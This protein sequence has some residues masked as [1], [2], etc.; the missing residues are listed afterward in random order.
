MIYVGIDIAKKK[1]FA[2]VMN[3][4]GEILVEAFS[5]NNDQDGFSSLL[6]KISSF[7]KK[8]VVIG[9][10][11]TARYG[12]NLIFFLFSLGYKVAIINPLQTSNLRKTNLRKT[13]TD[14]VDT[15]LI[16]KT[17]MIGEHH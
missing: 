11:S 14:K 17:L 6:S 1:H 13:K 7:E 3:S 16:I 4:D 8:D 9:L 10:E 5:F 15:Y 12:E 2:S